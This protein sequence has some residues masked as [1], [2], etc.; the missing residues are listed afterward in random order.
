MDA[1]GF[2]GF[3]T[4]YEKKNE[5]GTWERRKKKEISA[6]SSDLVNA[7]SQA[8]GYLKTY[9]FVNV[10]QDNANCVN[11]IWT[12]SSGLLDYCINV[13]FIRFRDVNGKN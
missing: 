7:R 5:V 12:C 1:I 2:G 10:S 9:V 4:G 8:S 11:S 13:M 6:V 3:L